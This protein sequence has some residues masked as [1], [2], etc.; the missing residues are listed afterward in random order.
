MAA[1]GAV[2]KQEIAQKL[3]KAFPN[4]FQ[5]DKDIRI[6]WV[7]NGQTVEIKN[8]ILLIDG[9]E[10]ESFG[11]TFNENENMS[12]ITVEKGCYFVIGDN[13]AN[14][15]DSRNVNFGTVAKKDIIGKVIFTVIHSK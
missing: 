10:N 14:S 7:E 15:E 3:F 4:A 2:A 5:H 6:P 12:A 9:Q 11:F 1:K 13:T 8:G